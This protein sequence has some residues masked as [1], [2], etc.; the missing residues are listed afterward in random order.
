M[1]RLR[2]RRPR[3]DAVYLM[4]PVL[5]ATPLHP[6]RPPPRPRARPAR[7]GGGGVGCGGLGGGGGG[8]AAGVV[9]VHVCVVSDA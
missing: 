5:C 2:Q 8:K 3:Q 4:H 7:A 9:D 6:P 1:T